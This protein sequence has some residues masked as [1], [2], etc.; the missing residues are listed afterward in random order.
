MTTHSLRKIGMSAKFPYRRKVFKTTVWKKDGIRSYGDYVL[1]SRAKGVAP[2]K[3]VLPRELEGKVFTGARLVYVRHKSYYEW[4]FISEVNAAPEKKT[5]GSIVSVDSGEIHPI[6]ITDG[7]TSLIISCR[8]LRSNRQGLAK[9]IALIDSKRA[10]KKAG[11]RGM[12]IL[13]RA[14]AKARRRAKAKQ[15]DMLH[16]VSRMA[17]DFAESRRAN[18]IAYGDVR[19][20]ADKINKGT[21]INQKIS[22]WPHGQLRSLI[23]YKA[24][25]NGI[26]VELQN[27]HFTSQSCPVCKTRNKTSGRN[28]ICRTCGFEGHRDGEVGAANIHSLKVH[29]EFGRVRVSNVKYRHPFLTGKRSRVDTAQVAS[30]KFDASLES[31]PI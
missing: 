7:E 26:S 23:Q 12:K 9:K 30:L 22:F 21:K 31:V 6:A 29:G 10:K 5:I 19:D 11:S 13:N 14:K 24:A 25:Q 28:Y 2:I 27:E 3:V 18:V 20:I 1:L 17:V 4:H 15:R 8:E 16:K